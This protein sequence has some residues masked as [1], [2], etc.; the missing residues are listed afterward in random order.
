MA[1][2]IIA[3]AVQ[4]DAAGNEI[5]HFELSKYASKGTSA[6]RALFIDCTQAYGGCAGS[7]RDADGH[8]L[9][10]LFTKCTKGKEGKECGILITNVELLD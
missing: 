4:R 10:W 7:V 6:R 9:S 8:T 2:R 5:A 3:R 1:N